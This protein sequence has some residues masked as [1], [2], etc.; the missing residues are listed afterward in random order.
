MGDVIVNTRFPKPK[1]DR[2]RE[3]LRRRFARRPVSRHARRDVELP[4]ATGWRRR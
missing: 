1:T 2:Q 4:P 3:T